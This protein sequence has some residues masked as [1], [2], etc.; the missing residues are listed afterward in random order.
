[1][2]KQENWARPEL[3][4]KMLE[5][6]ASEEEFMAAMDK[7]QAGI[8]ALREECR[9]AEVVVIFETPAMSKD[10]NG[11]VFETVGRGQLHMGCEAV[12]DILLARE[13]GR[14]RADRAVV[15]ARFEN[16]S[17]D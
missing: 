8:R 7:F 4:R 5:P 17:V 6:H 12:H 16:G 10:E 13:L 3:Y 14:L 2:S 1:M 11:E 15:L 9:V